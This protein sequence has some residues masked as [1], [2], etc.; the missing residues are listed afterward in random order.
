MVSFTEYLLG[1]VI[2]PPSAACA[3]AALA[4]IAS[5]SANRGRTLFL[6]LIEIFRLSLV[7]PDQ[8]R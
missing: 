5:E 6:N 3:V 1:L 4:R 8:T 7:S 2:R